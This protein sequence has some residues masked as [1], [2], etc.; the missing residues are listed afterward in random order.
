MKVDIIKLPPSRFKEA[1]AIR[2]EALKTNPE[3]FGETLENV[4]IYSDNKWINRLEKSLVNEGAF[5]YYA[6][7]DKRIV[8]MVGSYY[9]EG[10]KA[11]IFGMYVSPE[12]RKQN[13]G[14]ELL[15]KT[16]GTLQDELKIMDIFLWV[17]TKEFPAINLYK[18]TGFLIVKTNN[19]PHF[20][21]NKTF[22][23]Y[24]MKLENHH[25]KLP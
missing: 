1:K 9:P 3:S 11:E 5:T 20:L 16:I 10:I 14:I 8:G 4:L 13:I 19:K 24:Y 23:V 12:F 2:I 15:K 25:I 21:D 6:E 22:N 7:V 18:K 17:N